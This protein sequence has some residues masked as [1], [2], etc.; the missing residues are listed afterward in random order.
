MRQPTKTEEYAMAVADSIMS[1]FR[2][3]EDGNPHYHYDMEEID[4]TKFFTGMV[5]GCAYVFNKLTGEEK[6]FLEFT[7]IC[8]QLIVQHMLQEGIKPQD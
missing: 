7:H 8:N 1:L 6:N 3:D 5:M 4:A 2:D